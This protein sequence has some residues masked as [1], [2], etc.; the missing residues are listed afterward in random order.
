MLFSSV[1]VSVRSYYYHPI[2][3]GRQYTRLSV[4]VGASSAGVY[5]DRSIT[6]G[7]LFPSF[8]PS[9]GGPVHRV[10][11]SMFRTVCFILRIFFFSTAGSIS[12]TLDCFTTTYISRKVDGLHSR[13]YSSTAACCALVVSL[14][15]RT[16][17]EKRTAN[18]ELMT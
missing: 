3:S 4:E 17:H 18:M 2:S 16:G 13:R 9:L 14:S 11:S 10:R 1:C 5:T 7:I 12:S 15:T 6:T 8:L